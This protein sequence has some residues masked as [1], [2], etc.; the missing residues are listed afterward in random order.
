MATSARRQRERGDNV[1][2][3]LVG[4][5]IGEDGVA[6]IT[7]DRP[8][9]NALGN[10]V[11]TGLD[12]ACDRCDTEAVGAAVFRSAVP[13][14]FA[15]GADLKLLV[16]LD[17]E[18]FLDYLHRLR[19]VLERIAGAE[20]PS[21]AAI[22]GHALGGGLEL[23]M[24]ATLRVAS[25]SA[26]LGVPEVKLG[27]LPGATG[28]QRLPRL[29]G[30]GPALDLLLTGRSATA[31]EG[32]RWGLIDRLVEP[33]KAEVEAHRWAAAFAGGPRSAHAAIVRCVDAARD[34]PL[35]KGLDVEKDEIVDL[36]ATPDAREGITAFLEKRPARF[37]GA[38]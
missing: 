4:C 10:D 23:S 7:L 34:L 27:L 5:D 36:F 17:R 37:G 6:T 13:G 29:V 38:A 26:R 2:D 35:A 14:F 3:H 16:D 21:I 20:W 12:A 1:S 15:A 8:P 32:Y 22:D 11:I 9:A 24:A 33:G 19:A 31:E 18:K 25:P 30:R 28:T